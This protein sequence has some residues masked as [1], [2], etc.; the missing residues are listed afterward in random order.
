MTT[1]VKDG[2]ASPVSLA[3]DGGF[4]MDRFGQESLEW[5]TGHY[6]HLIIAVFVAVAVFLILNAVKRHLTKLAE[7]RDDDQGATSIVLRVVSR[8]GVFFLLALSMEMVAGLAEAPD[9]LAS[10]ID[11]IF[12]ISLVFQSAIWLRA[13]ILGLLDHRIKLSGRGQAELQNARNL[14]RLLVTIALAVIAAVIILDNIGVNVTALVAGLG[15]GGIAIGLAAQGIF[16]D[17]FA[18]LSIIFDKPFRKGDSIMFDDFDGEVEA[19]GLKTTRLRSITGEQVIISNTNLLDKQVRN[20][21]GLAKRRIRFPIG[22][23]Y[24]TTPEQLDAIP[25]IFKSIIE[26]HGYRYVRC[27]FIGFGDSS[28]NY[29]MEFE[30]FSSK[31]DEIFEGRHAVGLALVKRFAAESIEFAYPTQMNFTAGPDGAAMAPYTD[32]K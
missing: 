20:M 32:D 15:V 2:I 22:V 17:L 10:I 16:S 3:D 6:D 30:I 24:Q 8:T 4:D 14:I 11:L 31:W 7:K 25:E 23:I 12:F 9:Q 19:T 28:L 5:I 27:G 13:I 1:V 26:E 21:T 29:R 18:A